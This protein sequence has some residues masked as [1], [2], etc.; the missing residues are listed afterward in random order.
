MNNFKLYLL[1]YELKGMAY[2]MIQFAEQQPDYHPLLD[3]IQAKIDELVELV[4][5]GEGK[6]ATTE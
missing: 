5:E 1:I 6:V 3:D 2:S 4:K